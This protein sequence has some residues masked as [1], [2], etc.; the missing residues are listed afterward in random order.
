MTCRKEAERIREDAEHG[1]W[2]LGTRSTRRVLDLLVQLAGRVDY[3]SDEA[4]RAE[5]ERLSGYPGGD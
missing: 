1:G 3:L 2:K 5:R 4:R